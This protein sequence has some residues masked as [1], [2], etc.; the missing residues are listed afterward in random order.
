VGSQ[1]NEES[2]KGNVFILKTRYDYLAL[3]YFQKQAMQVPSVLTINNL[4]TDFQKTGLYMPETIFTHCKMHVTF[5]VQKLQEVG[6]T[7]T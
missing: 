4:M 1:L 3:K 6:S 5:P 7:K 2:K